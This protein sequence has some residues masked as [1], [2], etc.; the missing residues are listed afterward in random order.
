MKYSEHDDFFPMAIWTMRLLV[1]IYDEYNRASK[2]ILYNQILTIS[3]S[4]KPF[5]ALKFGTINFRGCLNSL[6]LLM[7]VP[8]N[9]VVVAS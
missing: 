2:I 9:L 3:S 7:L 4:K 6:I 5:I 8:I 1:F